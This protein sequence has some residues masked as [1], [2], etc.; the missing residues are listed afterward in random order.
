[1]NARRKA[2]AA[3]IGG[4]ATLAAGWIATQRHDQEAIEAD[5]RGEALFAEFGGER[6][7]VR[8]ADGTALWVRSFGPVDAPTLIFVHGWTCAA[9]FWKL[10]AE[11]LKG[12]RRLVA[13][14]LRGH[15]QSERPRDR[16]YSI[17]TF[18][19]DLDS[20]I[21]RCV[22]A[23]ERVMLIG[24]SLGAM[25]IVAWAGAHPE[26]VD[27][28]V[29]SAVLVNTGVGDLISES[30]VIEGFPDGFAALQRL[31]GEGVLRARAPI[32][33]FSAPIS[34]RVIRY[35]VTGPDASPAQV[36]FCEH[37]VLSCPADVRGAVGGTLSRLD[38]RHAL[39]HL[40][41]P[42][43]V[44]AG[45]RDRLTPPK[46]ALEMAEELPDVL[47][48]IVIPRS[49]HMSPVEFPDEVNRPLAELAG[50][51]LVATAV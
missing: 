27:S 24:H 2:L 28:R 9:E 46:H 33:T 16:N 20:V 4:A 14:D 39:E 35:A 49:G 50:A 6:Q 38:L 17:E 47:D 5:P 31:A 44:I 48:L 36:A 13:F 11:A 18:A 26:K 45:E 21:E 30:L 37:L 42:T 10:Q 12:E 34:N 32:P 8:A 7:V 41:V 25:T 51:P 43:L 22:P 15:G 40:T 3:G 1:M 19:T 29:A 23:G